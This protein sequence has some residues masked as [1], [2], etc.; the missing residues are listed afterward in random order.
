[1]TFVNTWQV[2]GGGGGG[3]D[4]KEATAMDPILAKFVPL[5]DSGLVTQAMK[6]ELDAAQKVSGRMTCPQTAIAHA[7]LLPTR[8]ALNACTTRRA[9]PLLLHLS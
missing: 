1:M 6:D 9:A 7:H 5:A 3:G 8:W 4:A 2:G